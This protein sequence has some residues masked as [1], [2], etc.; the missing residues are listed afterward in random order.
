MKV[1]T[2]FSELHG[3]REEIIRFT[4]VFPTVAAMLPRINEFQNRNAVYLNILQEKAIAII[5]KYV[6]KDG[7]G[8]FEKLTAEDGTE[9][10]KFL[11]PEFEQKFTDEWAEL[12]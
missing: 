9:K 11:E 1:N 12:M 7:D 8:K 3:R 2:T 10:W 6:S 5:E 4:Q